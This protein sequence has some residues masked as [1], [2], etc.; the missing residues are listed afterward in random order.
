MLLKIKAIMLDTN[1][2]FFFFCTEDILSWEN[3]GSL[4]KEECECLALPLGWNLS[5][6]EIS[7]TLLTALSRA[8]TLSVNALVFSH[9]PAPAELHL[10]F[11]FLLLQVAS[12]WLQSE[13]WLRIFLSGKCIV[14]V[15]SMDYQ[16][17]C[18]NLWKSRGPVI[19]SECLLGLVPPAL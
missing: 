4:Q 1:G 7:K 2:V 5:C 13:K 14:N 6:T 12:S 8:R 9:W 15:L 18:N 10:S 11:S 17:Q 19:K 16:L 3:L